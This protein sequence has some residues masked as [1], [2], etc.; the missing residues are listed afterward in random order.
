MGNP[1]VI[2]EAQARFDLH[3]DDGTD[4]SGTPMS[5]KSGDLFGESFTLHCANTMLASNRDAAGGW[6]IQK[7]S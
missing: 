1:S 3:D 7:G 4:Y 5:D 6:D 2:N